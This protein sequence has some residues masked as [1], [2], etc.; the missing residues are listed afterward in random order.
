ML[1]LVDNETPVWLDGAAATGAVI[2]YARFHCGCR[3]TAGPRD[4]AIA[5]VTD[6]GDMPFL[7]AFA[8]GNDEYPDRSA[9]L[10]VQVP[11]LAGGRAL[12]MTGPGIRDKTKLAVAGLP[13]AFPD[14]W[15]DNQVMFPCGVDMIFTNRNKI[16]C[17]AALLPLGGL[18]HVCCGQRRRKGH[19]QRPSADGRGTPWRQGAGR[20]YLGPDRGAAGLAVDRV[21]TEA[22]LYDR[23]LAA[24]AIKQAG[25]DLVEAVFLLRAYR[26]TLPRFGV[27][28]PI[29]TAAMAIRRRISSAFKDLPGGQVLGPTYDYTHRLLDFDLAAPG[30]D[31]GV[32]QAVQP[33]DFF[34]PR[35][36]DVLGQEGLLEREI[37]CDGAPVP[38][39][40]RDPPAY[41]APRALR[42]QNSGAR[43]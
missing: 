43:R 29:D 2:D 38:D 6:V 35:V 13:S 15:R 40:T 41:P 31:A 16:G 7:S 22:S 5:I 11:S 28:R 3:L 20:A 25:G 37:R 18:S 10:I 9:T 34:I 32:Q 36:T 1:T 42:L 27:S 12:G 17:P 21:M 39:L 8:A 26:T 4:A 24:L 19:R 30:A 33:V 23:E 14:W